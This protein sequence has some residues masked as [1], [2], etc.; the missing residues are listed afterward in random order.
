MIQTSGWLQINP[1]RNTYR[2]MI[3]FLICEAPFCVT[4]RH[5]ITFFLQ[6]KWRFKVKVKG[7]GQRSRS[8]QINIITKI[9]YYPLL[10]CE[11]SD[12]RK[13]YWS[14]RCLCLR[15]CLSV[16]K[17]STVR[18]AYPIIMIFFA[19]DVFWT[20]DNA[21]LFFLKIGWRAR[22]RSPLLWK[23]DNGS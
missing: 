16:F 13:V 5:N 18:T 14:P 7:Q 15:V 10:L 11:I 23:S 6:N 3:T 12:F 17:G 19:E 21:E 4:W 8:V 9:P 22:S 2:R 1:W 20:R